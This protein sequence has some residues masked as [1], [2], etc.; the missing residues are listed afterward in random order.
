MVCTFSRQ[1]ITG[2]SCSFRPASFHLVQW[3][4][5]KKTRATV[6]QERLIT[7]RLLKWCG[8]CKEAARQILERDW[9]RRSGTHPFQ[10]NRL[11]VVTVSSLLTK[12]ATCWKELWMA[13]KA[14]VFN[15]I[16]KCNDKAWNGME[17][18]LPGRRKSCCKYTMWSQCW[19]F[20]RC[21]QIYPLRLCSWGRHSQQSLLF[22]SERMSVG[23]RVPHQKWAV[24]KQ[25]LGAVAWQC[26]HSLHV[27]GEAVSCCQTELHDPATPIL[28]RFGT[29][30]LLFLKVNWP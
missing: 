25:Q 4:C 12:T 29:S 9:Q 1:G 8:I 16:L 17:W 3:K 14:C 18:I 11:N 23:V 10:L 21:C 30:R 7:T 2:R 27:E 13:M 26:T 28:A 22:S 19:M 20:F 24:P 15:S 6:T 5:G